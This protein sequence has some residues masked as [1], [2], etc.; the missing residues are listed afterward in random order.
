MT[1]YDVRIWELRK[2]DGRR[3]PWQVRWTVSGSEKSRTFATKALA[4]GFRSELNQSAR[5]GEAFDKTSGLP[6]RMARVPSSR[7]WLDHARAYVDMKWP[8][9]AANSRESMAESLA[10]VSPA[11]VKA[12]GGA[13]DGRALRR[14]LIGWAFCPP[15]RVITPPDDVAAALRWLAKASRPLVELAEP[16]VIRTA[17]DALAVT[18][19]GR[20]AAA[21]TIRRKRA[22]FYNALEFAVELGELEANPIDRVK[23]RAPEIGVHVD[24]RVVA[25]PA[26]VRELLTGCTYVGRR[27][28]GRR[29]VGFFACL[30]FAAL[31]PSEAAALREGDCR[32][33]RSGWGELVLTGSLPP[34]GTRWTDDGAVHEARGLKHR[35]AR[36]T[37]VVPIPPELC[38]ILRD[39]VAR[40]GAGAD[41]RLFRSERGGRL[42]PSAY[43]YVWSQA[44][45]LA[46]PEDLAA[47]PL[48]ARPYDL[49]HAGVSLWLNAGVPATEVA[50]RA[51]HS[52]DVLLKVYAKCIDGQGDVLNARID[53]ALS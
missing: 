29:L 52:V 53:T 37:R 8:K 36:D 51:G 45:R 38:S 19:D 7:S 13:P 41:G 10:T 17:L 23:W 4:E 34:S 30:Y 42:Q 22:V 47:S 33:S 28:R 9:A 3:R 46:L 16:S 12:R 14:G 26:Q 43:W 48:A 31:R 35:P 25:S 18:L 11:L 2:L 27:D 24:R 15:R 21:E 1:V 39:H 40:F 32:F 20:P 50:A 6:A 49:R 44:R 5:R